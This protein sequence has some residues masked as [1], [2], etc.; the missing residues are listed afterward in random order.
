MK[1][2]SPL[3]PDSDQVA[4]LKSF[5]IDEI[6]S[7]WLSDFSIDISEEISGIKNIDL[8]LCGQTSLRFFVPL[9]ATGSEKIYEQLE[10]FDWYYMPV[11]WEHDIAVKDLVGCTRILEIGCGKGA[12]VQR[13]QKNGFEVEGIEMNPKAVRYAQE[14]HIPVL[15][16]SLKDLLK[17]EV[18][19]FDA[20]CTFQV[21]EHVSDPHGFLKDIVDLVRKDGKI[22]IGVPNADSFLKYQFNVL[23]MPPHHMTQWSASTFHYLEKIF[24]IKVVSVLSEPLSLIHANGYL[25]AYSQKWVADYPVLKLVFNR[26]TLPSLMRLFRAAIRMGV[27]RFLVGQSLYVCFEKL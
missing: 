16:K 17:S 24:P 21:L 4:L 8:Y 13:L 9:D 10:D 25:M 15:L 27:G 18:P 12:F 19:K 1:I 2:C 11:K 20:V 14:Q 22:I 6:K 23:D 5:S 3:I 26:L 7:R